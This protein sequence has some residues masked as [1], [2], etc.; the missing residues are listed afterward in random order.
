MLVQTDTHV[1]SGLSRPRTTTAVLFVA[2]G[3]V[4]VAAYY[5]DL[6]ATPWVLAALVGVA[7]HGRVTRSAPTPAAT[8]GVD[9]A[10][11]VAGL[12]LGVLAFGGALWLAPVVG[13]ACVGALVLDARGRR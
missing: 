5:G 6:S 4:G 3:L 11:F 8:R 2:A 7:L 12:A 13:L 9:A 10:L 1:R